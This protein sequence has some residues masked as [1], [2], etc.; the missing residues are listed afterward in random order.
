MHRSWLALAPV[1]LLAASPASSPWPGGVSLPPGEPVS[2]DYRQQ[3]GRCDTDGS[4]RG[5]SSRYT[6]C[7][8]D[9]N[10]VAAL[11]R[12][13]GG[14]VA[15]VSKLAVDLDG[16]AFA[17]GP[18]HGRMDQC[19]TSLMLPDGHGGDRKSVV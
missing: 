11:R 1:L 19:P 6:H 10:R 5:I 8:G 4:F 3:F 15:W 7:A 14:A 2:E 16:S 9:P 12:L 18:H 17:C 13:P